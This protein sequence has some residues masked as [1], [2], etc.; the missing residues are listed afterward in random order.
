M[1][2]LLV[3]GAGFLGSHVARALVAG[4]HR[5]TVLSRGRRPL[6]EGCFGLIADRTDPVSLGS[7]L[8]G[9]HFDFTVDL[10]AYDAGDVERLLL[11]PYTALG[12]YV[13]ISSGQV[14][15]VTDAER[16]PYREGDEAHRVRPEP[17]P[18]SYD[19]ASWAYGVGKRR[20]EQALLALRA[21]HGVRGTILRLPIL[22]GEGDASLR[23]WGWIERLLDG[24]P[25]L[26]PDGGTRLTRHLWAGDAARVIRHL[27]EGPLPR[28]AAYNLAQPD[29]VTLR[30]FLGRVAAI[31]G[32][33]PRWVDA[34]WD[35][36]LARGAEPDQF[37]YAGRWSS[38]LDPS[39]A[40]AEWGVLPRRL[41]EY[42]PEVVLWY[43]EHRPAESHPG[44]A[45][46]ALE[47]AIAA[48]LAPAR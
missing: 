1:D 20:A 3:G 35:E 29:V 47:R 46:R 21:S 48:E 33:E 24:G 10:T 37:P 34:S 32:V 42:L 5:V 4:G 25:L 44:Y 41:D 14:Y 18:G 38:L 13:L 11:V 26:L 23:L 15:L 45:R 39:Q 2:V 8:E 16:V 27:A 31:L 43:V 7:M 6:P 9:R 30:D 28:E 12:R 17:E 22:Q 40:V 36:L 19:H